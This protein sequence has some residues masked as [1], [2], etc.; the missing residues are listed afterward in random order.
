MSRFVLIFF[1][2]VALFAEESTAQ[3]LA[4]PGAEGFGKFTTGGRGGKVIVVTNLHDD[5]P[6]SL[7]DAIQKKTPRIIVFAVSGTIALAS[8]LDINHGDVTIA[9]QSA[10]GDG[11]CIRNFTVNV[12]VDNV[13]I[14]FLR[15]RLGDESKYE[16]DAF[17]GN[18]DAQNIIIDHCSMS[19]STDECASF[20]RNKNFTMQ[21]CII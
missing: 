19:W 11:I 6:G 21:W 16:G 20:Y 8:P 7:R 2:S 13:I 18:R 12:K 10:P 15:F 5:G 9:G 4:F 1:L 17:S 14:R 3:T